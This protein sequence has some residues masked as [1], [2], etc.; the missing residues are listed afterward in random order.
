MFEAYL[1]S[2]KKASLVT[3]KNG[4]K[5]EQER[6]KANL[7]IWRFTNAV[8]TY[9]LD[10]PTATFVKGDMLWRLSL[11]VE[12]WSFISS[13]ELL[14]DLNNKDGNV[15]VANYWVDEDGLDFHRATTLKMYMQWF[16]TKD[17]VLHA[18]AGPW[19]TALLK[20]LRYR[21]HGVTQAAREELSPAPQAANS[22]AAPIVATSKKSSSGYH[23]VWYAWR[24]IVTNIV[25][26]DCDSSFE[27]QISS[28]PPEWWSTSKDQ[29]KNCRVRWH[30]PSGESDLTF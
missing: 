30:Y 5:N 26:R 9:F 24:E 7:W 16:R 29:C 22:Q 19:N 8:A 20:R 23:V 14:T 1:I 10:F 25:A 11:I 4:S 3:G 15:H 13:E 21:L 28:E 12:E 17:V 27:R 2:I 6:V 18:I